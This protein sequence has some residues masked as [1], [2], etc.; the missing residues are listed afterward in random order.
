VHGQFVEYQTVSGADPL[1]QGDVLEAVDTDSSAW[2]MHLIVITADCDFAFQKHRGRVT[3]VPLLPADYYLLQMQIP[4]L[5]ETLC[6]K[7]LTDFKQI[8]ARSSRSAIT[9]ERLI[10]WIIENDAADIVRSLELAEKYTEKASQLIGSLKLIYSTQSSLIEASHALVD[11]QLAANSSL[12][13]ASAVK[14]VHEK[15]QSTFSQTPGDALF[16]SAFA[17][18][19]EDG[20]FAYLRHLEQIWEPEIAITP[21]R[22]E[23]NYR[24]VARLRDRYVHAL[25]QRFAMVFMPIGLP[26]EYENMRSFHSDLLTEAIR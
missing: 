18:N 7:P 3:C 11:A 10:E 24:R 19:H 12:S 1:R 4:R 14:R 17:P 22:R 21:G 16:V 15:I 8:L 6:K 26:D 9:D 5:R 23:V 2:Q 20:Y 13:R 25:V